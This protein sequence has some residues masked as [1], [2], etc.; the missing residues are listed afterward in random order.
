MPSYIFGLS[1]DD[2]RMVDAVS[3]LRPVSGSS[4]L[5]YVAR[6]LDVEIARPGRG[7]SGLASFFSD[8]PPWQREGHSFSCFLSGPSMDHVRH[9][10][11]TS[12]DTVLP[13]VPRGRNRGTT[14]FFGHGPLDTDEFDRRSTELRVAI[15]IQGATA[16]AILGGFAQIVIRIARKRLREQSEEEEEMDEELLEAT[17]QIK[18][19]PPVEAY[20]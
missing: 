18:E 19:K 5:K 13:A 15:G 4:R 3:C 2:T 11:L 7:S 17:R 10:D 14:A 6:P 16:T 8:G 20:F 9:R 1:D 12:I